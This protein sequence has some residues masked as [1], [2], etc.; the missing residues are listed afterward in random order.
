MRETKDVNQNV[1][2]F[3]LRQVPMDTEK[4]ESALILAK[5]ISIPSEWKVGGGEPLAAV[6]QLMVGRRALERPSNKKPNPI[7]TLISKMSTEKYIYFMHLPW[8]FFTFQKMVCAGSCSLHAKMYIPHYMLALGSYMLH[9]E[10]WN[11]NLL[12]QSG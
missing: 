12:G 5:I 8:H 9:F 7:T 4:E 11:K 2:L 1:R 3:H 6:R 10:V